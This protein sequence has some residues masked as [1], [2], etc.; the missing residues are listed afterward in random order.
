MRAA[1][2]IEGNPVYRTE[3]NALVFKLKSQGIT[4]CD[5]SLSAELIFIA[6]YHPGD[7]RELK[8][9]VKQAKLNRNQVYVIFGFSLPLSGMH[10]ECDTVFLIQPGNMERL[11]SLPAYL[12]E[13]A[14]NASL[15]MLAKNYFIDMHN[16][17]AD[18]A[19][20]F[21]HSELCL[22]G[23]SRAVLNIIRSDIQGRTVPV[24]IEILLRHLREIE[25]SVIKE[26][27]EGR[28]GS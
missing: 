26:V 4:I 1:V 16:E 18:A 15:Y 3:I 9:I 8:R 20:A 13:N 23:K 19:D 24:P 2:L 22:I 27:K 21:S 12:N 10:E 28:V 11:Y 5:D 7:N 17:S 6:Y 14:D 25:T